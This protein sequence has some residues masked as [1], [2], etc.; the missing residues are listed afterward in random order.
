[1]K[2]EVT[3]NLANSVGPAYREDLEQELMFLDKKLLDCQKAVEGPKL[4]GL[5]SY[6]IRVREISF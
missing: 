5:A 3:R 4:L 2:R 6:D 1:M